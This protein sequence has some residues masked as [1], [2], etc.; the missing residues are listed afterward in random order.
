MRRVSQGAR[1]DHQAGWVGAGLQIP[2]EAN[3]A[4]SQRETPEAARFSNSAEVQNR[5]PPG[6]VSGSRGTNV[7]LAKDTCTHV[8]LPGLTE[9]FHTHKAS[10]TL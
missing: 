8:P 2:A 6:D 3:A 7:P 5:R 1:T 4:W 9:A 10:S